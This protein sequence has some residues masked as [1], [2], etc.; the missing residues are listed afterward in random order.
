MRVCLPDVTNEMRCT[1]DVLGLEQGV[2]YWDFSDA[3]H[4]LSWSNTARSVVQNGVWC[5]VSAKKRLP[6]LWAPT[7][8]IATAGELDVAFCRMRLSGPNIS[9][10]VR[11]RCTLSEAGKESVVEQSVQ[12]PVNDQWYTHIFPFGRATDWRGTLTRIE[13]MP[14]SD[15]AIQITLDA[16]GIVQ[17]ARQAKDGR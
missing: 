1:L 17:P 10:T 13:L 12:V 3:A 5:S 8:P 9:T 7:E 15:P 11:L 16:V 2:A 14:V 4:A 6:V